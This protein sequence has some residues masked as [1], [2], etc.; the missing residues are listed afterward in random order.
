MTR[1]AVTAP[2]A[3][4]AMSLP[5]VTVPIA[6]GT[7]TFPAVTVPVAAGIVAVVP[8]KARPKW[9]TYLYNGYTST[10]ILRLFQ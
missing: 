10:Q 7:M 5:A 4:G 1:P 2:I 9:R 8:G 6:A 3:A